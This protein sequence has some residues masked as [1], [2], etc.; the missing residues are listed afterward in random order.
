MSWV[1]GV[2]NCR[3]RLGSFDRFRVVI[4]HLER[5][6]YARLYLHHVSQLFIPVKTL[7]RML[8]CYYVDVASERANTH[9]RI[10][11]KPQSLRVDQ[12]KETRTNV[13]PCVSS[14]CYWY[15][16]HQNNDYS[17]D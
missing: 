2:H 6:M 12:K 10:T 11:P 16:T 13:R 9:E 15:I 7:T 4:L 17:N 5:V 3:R 14:S 1:L 8:I